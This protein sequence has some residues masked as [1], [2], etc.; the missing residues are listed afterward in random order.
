MSAA[1]PLG[2][3]ITRA[4]IEAKFRELEG[5]VDERKEQAFSIAVAVGAAL[6]VG[7]AISGYILGRRR[8]R[9]R[10]TVVEIRRV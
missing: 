7:I 9:K 2:R 8:G 1:Q 6:V 5:E 3:H 10:T 4:D